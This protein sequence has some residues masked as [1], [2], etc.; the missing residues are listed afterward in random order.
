MKGRIRMMIC[1]A[2]GLYIGV[3][4]G[5]GYKHMEASPKREVFQEVQQ[6]AALLE[7]NPLRAMKGN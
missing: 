6:I 7:M 2:A 1:F 4:V 3:T 5:Y